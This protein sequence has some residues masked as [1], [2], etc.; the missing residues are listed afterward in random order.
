VPA[1]LVL[2]SLAALLTLGACRGSREARLEEVRALQDAGLY[3]ETV[4]PLRELVAE[5]PEQPEANYRLGMALLRTGQA[6]RAVWPLYKAAASEAFAVPA[7]MAI[8]STL[9][10]QDQHEEAYAAASRVLEVE[11]DHEGAL[12]IRA[13]AGLASAQPEQALADAEHLV[14]LSPDRYRGLEAAALA[15]L[16]RLDEAEQAYAEF[17]RAAERLDPQ[18]ATQACFEVA[19]FYAESREDAEQAGQQIER[20]L[21]PNPAQFGSV[22]RAVE[23]YDGLERPEQAMAVLRRAVEA[24]PVSL[25]L[26][27][28]LSDRLLADG[29]A[30]EAEAQLREAAEALDSPDA[31]YAL[32]VLRRKSGDPDG[33]REAIERAR[34]LAGGGESEELRFFL[35]DL[36]A[37]QGELDEAERIANGL[38]EPSYRDIARGRILLERG[39]SAEAL[40]AL[41]SGLQVW[42]NNPGARMLAA[43]AALDLGDTSRAMIDL[44]EATRLAPED[45]DAALLLGRLY[46]AQGNFASAT[47]LLRRHVGAQGIT[48]PEAHVLLASAAAQRG[49]YDEARTWLT[50]LRENEEYQGRAVAEL[51]R[52]ELRAGGPEAALRSIEDSGLDLSDPRNEPATRQWIALLLATGRLEPARAWAEQVASSDSPSLQAARAE[53]LLELGEEAAARAAFDAALEA[54]PESASALAGLGQL[55]QRAGDPEAALALF[56][57]AVAADSAHPN[58]AYL[59]AS[60]GLALGRT[61]EAKSAL[62]TLLRRHPEH[63]AACNDLA[64]LL[65][66]EGEELDLALALAERAIR[67]DARPEVLDTLGWVRLR[68]GEIEPAI[69]AFE[70]ALAER[71]EYSTARYHLGLALARRGDAGAARQ[72]FDAALAAGPFPESEAARRELERLAAEEP[73]SL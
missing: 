24:D 9:L 15:A 55:E 14:A 8:A 47:S 73:S 69:A 19:R 33:A 72:A 62:R 61:D 26:R 21:E 70:R 4:E 42:P 34:G 57:R 11:P 39:E 44:R 60:A 59:A 22:T 45:N 53:L 7:G 51:A 2:A 31:W 65:A 12:A 71:P 35:A 54:D 29:E 30:E 28:R 25:R 48:G 36:L 66:E 56:D 67:L 13:Q 18:T 43:E 41:E 49:N 6:S 5:N 64:W 68:R 23:L 16:G 17:E 40:E 63:V 3:A 50:A 32:A 10:R 27:Q 37:E 38:V 1:L 20:C 46:L 52:V 58:Y